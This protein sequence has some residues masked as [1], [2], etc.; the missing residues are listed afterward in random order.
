[1]KR[2]VVGIV[3][4]LCL[5]AGE[6]SANFDFTDSALLKRLVDK[7]EWYASRHMALEQKRLEAEEWQ[8]RSLQRLV[9]VAERQFPPPAEKK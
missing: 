9:W 6:A 7:V 3:I 2:L 4:G 1:M 5:S 8:A